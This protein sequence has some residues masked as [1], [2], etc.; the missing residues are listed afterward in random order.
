MLLLSSV[1]LAGALLLAPQVLASQRDPSLPL[2]GNGLQIYVEVRRDRGERRRGGEGGRGGR[3]A[4]GSSG[5]CVE[6]CEVRRGGCFV[7]ESGG[8]WVQVAAAN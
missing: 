7:P 6:A 4:P 3:C 1:A 5:S 2:G 8:S